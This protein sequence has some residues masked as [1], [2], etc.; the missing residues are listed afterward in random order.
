MMVNNKIT[1]VWICHFSN[2]EVQQL[3]PLWKTK[4]EYASWIPNTLKEFE[5]NKNIELHVI[6]PHEYL[7]KATKFDLRNIHY[8]FIP[9]GIPIWHRHWP[10]PFFIDDYTNFLFFRKKVEK[11]VNCIKPDIINLQGAE[12][13]YYSSSIFNLKE[14][15][16]ILIMVQGIIGLSC[17]IKKD[18]QTRNRI[19]IEN[20]IFREFKY[21]CGDD[22]TS[23]YIKENVNN[24][25]KFHTLYYP[26]N[27]KLLDTVESNKKRYDCMFYGRITK[28]KGIEDFIK[29]ISVLKKEKQNLK[30]CI[31]GHGSNNYVNTI[32]K[33]ILDLKCENNIEFIG[34]VSEQKILF[35]Y[36]KSSKTILVPTYNDRLPSTIRESIY[37]KTAVISYATGNIPFINKTGENIIITKV[38]DYKAMAKKVLFLLKDIRYREILTENAYEFY[39]KEFSGKVNTNRFINAYKTIIDISKSNKE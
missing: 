32:K 20:K 22:D 36:V 8:H 18:F 12:N 27:E 28:D 10:S 29:I 26:A 31:L 35:E 13:A 2:A 5:N 4:N 38:G 16:P 15:Y 30:A 6:A 14:K 11:V 3:L 1:V 39:Q 19:R 23:D 7:K 33:R 34:Y 25:H 9:F 37:L 17:Q 21:F 24:N